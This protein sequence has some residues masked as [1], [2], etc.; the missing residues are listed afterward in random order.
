MAQ[1]LGVLRLAVETI[2]I[3]AIVATACASQ[4]ATPVIGHFTATLSEKN[5]ITLDWQVSGGNSSSLLYIYETVGFQA[6]ACPN[7]L[8]RYPLAGGTADL[9]PMPTA[10]RSGAFFGGFP[11]QIRVDAD[12]C[13]SASTRTT[14]SSASTRTIPT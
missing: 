8:G 14:R 11:W 9:F 10:R 7:L 5:K 6:Q 3:A 2:A 4:A 1:G 12:A 13:T